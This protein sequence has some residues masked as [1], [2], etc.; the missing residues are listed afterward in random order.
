[1]KTK[2]FK[3]A[4]S[5]ACAPTAL[6]MAWLDS[7]V[8]SKM[9]DAEAKIDPK[10]GGDFS[11]WDDYLTG[12]TL[13]ID[14]AN[15]RIVQSWRDNSTDWPKDYYSKITLEFAHDKTNPSHTRLRFW[16]SGIPAEYVDDIAA[17][18][19]EFFWEPM[20]KY[21]ATDI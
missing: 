4:P 14:P 19:K 16:H 7:D 13:E 12:T 1:M 18:W 21:F 8:I 15:C 9:I 17:G 2:Q 11:F 3:Q 20:Q 5:F 6:F 10:V